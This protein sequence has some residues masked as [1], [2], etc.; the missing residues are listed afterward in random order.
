MKSEQEMINA[1]AEIGIECV[2]VMVALVGMGSH[3]NKFNKSLRKMDIHEAY[4][5][6]CNG[7]AQK[8]DPFS[9]EWK[10]M[11]KEM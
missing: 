5:K 9:M 7:M 3:D 10:R 6:Y 8:Y 1:L 11:G 4:E 2:P